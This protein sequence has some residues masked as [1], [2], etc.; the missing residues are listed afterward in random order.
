MT[1]EQDQLPKP[2]EPAKGNSSFT[3]LAS[4]PYTFADPQCCMRYAAEIWQDER[5][6][7]LVTF[8]HEDDCEVWRYL[9]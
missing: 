4:M 5:D 8:T 7:V 2:A 6:Q 1:T 9:P 3:I